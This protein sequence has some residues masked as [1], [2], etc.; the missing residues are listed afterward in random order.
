MSVDPDGRGRSEY[1]CGMRIIS[2]E[3]RHRKLLSPPDGASTRPIPDRVKESLFNL[4]RGHFEDAMVFD[5]FSGTGSIGLEA[6]SRGAKLVVMV[7]KDRKVAETL[8]KNAASLGV[9]PRVEIV[10]GDALGL[11][12]LA[13]CPRPLNLAFFD[14]PY[15]F[16]RDRAGYQRVRAQFAQV[17]QRLTPEGFACLRTPWPFKHQEEVEPT[18]AD[19]LRA[20]ELSEQADRPRRKPMKKRG[21]NFMREIEEME[22]SG[23]APDPFEV[24]IED[25]DEEAE[26]RSAEQAETLLTPKAKFFD[27]DLSIH[28]AIGPETHEYGSTAVHIYMRDQSAASVG[29]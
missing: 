9:L 22:V 3:L 16:V 29:S 8:Y 23:H 21:R 7:E 24:E 28:G 5:A 2:G 20:A 15:D 14:P 13:R 1:A 25:V 18:A 4:L 27:V 11:G 17:V 26:D 12:S 19:V 6:V 10:T